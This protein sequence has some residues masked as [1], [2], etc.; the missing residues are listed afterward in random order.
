MTA[1]KVNVYWSVT[2]LKWHIFDWWNSDWC[3]SEQPEYVFNY[4]FLYFIF[5]PIAELEYNSK[6]DWWFCCRFLCGKEIKKRKCI[7]RLRTRVPPNPPSKLFPEKAQN[8]EGHRGSKKGTSRNRLV[9]PSR[10]C[11]CFLCE[12]L[13]FFT[14]VI[15]TCYGRRR[16]IDWQLI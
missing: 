5:T 14:S 3:I 10:A 9:M 2:W 1:S 16:C 15:M 6:T 12:P 13:L 11:P 7:F 4:N 8:S